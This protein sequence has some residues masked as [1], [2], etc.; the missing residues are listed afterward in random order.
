MDDRE[1]QSARVR[2]R[3]KWVYGRRGRR[4]KGFKVRMGV[5]ADHRTLDGWPTI[6]GYSE[7][8]H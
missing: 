4:V 7:R 6:N 3:L 8:H 5:V 1:L 2:R